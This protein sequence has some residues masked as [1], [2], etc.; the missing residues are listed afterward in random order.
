MLSSNLS[1]SWRQ[2]R[3]LHTHHL[4]SPW[5]GVSANSMICFYRSTKCFLHQSTRAHSCQ[6]TCFIPRPDIYWTYE[7]FHCIISLN[8]RD[9]VRAELQ[10]STGNS[11]TFTTLQFASM[12]PGA[13][14]SN[15][16]SIAA[17]QS[18]P[19]MQDHRS[20]DTGRSYVHAGSST[21]PGN[22]SFL[23]R[24]VVKRSPPGLLQLPKFNILGVIAS[25]VVVL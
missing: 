17:R 15:T 2:V 12:P 6:R 19:V 3:L 21:S 14:C 7:P 10:G 23:S 20:V 5:S 4:P 18:L 13:R 11:V 16:P 22:L 1:S 25:N 24:K 8:C 9:T